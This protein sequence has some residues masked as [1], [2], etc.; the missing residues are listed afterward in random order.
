MYKYQ[1]PDL[2]DNSPVFAVVTSSK[3]QK[4]GATYVGFGE[5]S[6]ARDGCCLTT[7]GTG[8]TGRGKLRKRWLLLNNKRDWQDWKR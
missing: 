4:D 7:K 8:K 2:V 1:R 6:C 5:G 3:V